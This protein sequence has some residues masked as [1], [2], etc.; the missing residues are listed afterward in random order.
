VHTK[1]AIVSVVLAIAIASVAHSAGPG[2]QTGRRA[3]A[4]PPEFGDALAGFRLRRPDGP[5]AVQRP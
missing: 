5:E 1:V 2:R 3:I 4:P